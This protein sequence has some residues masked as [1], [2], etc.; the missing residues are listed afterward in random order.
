MKRE[1]HGRA[2][3]LTPTEI[4]LLFNQGILNCGVALIG[5]RLFFYKADSPVRLIMCEGRRKT[6]PLALP[7]VCASCRLSALLGLFVE[8]GR[9]PAQDV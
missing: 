8:T 7:N 5:R 6:A 2:K 9:K 3:I 4:Q 1:R